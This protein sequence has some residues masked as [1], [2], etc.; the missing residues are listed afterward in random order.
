V[1]RLIR[2]GIVVLSDIPSSAGEIRSLHTAAFGFRPSLS[3]TEYRIKEKMKD[4]SYQTFGYIL[5]GS[6]A[7]FFFMK[8][9]G[10]N[11]PKHIESF[12]VAPWH[13]G[14]G[15]GSIMLKFIL[16]K[17]SLYDFYLTV[18]PKNDPAR[19]LYKKFDFRDTDRITMKRSSLCSS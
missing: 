17:Y 9:E 16:D 13:K 15:L 1:I 14:K 3:M 8:D 4:P 6:L 5:N 12:C 10:Y 7:G 2:D 19:G 18:A 11:D